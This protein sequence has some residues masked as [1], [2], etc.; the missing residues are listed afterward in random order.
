MFKITKMNCTMTNKMTF[1]KK[2]IEKLDWLNS[3]TKKN[4]IT[5]L[6]QNQFRL[7]IST[8]TIDTD[9]TKK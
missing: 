7:F 3:H 4:I 5:E 6:I 2:K 1:K 8:A 9:M